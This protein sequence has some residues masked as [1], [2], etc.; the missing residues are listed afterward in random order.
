MRF[1]SLAVPAIAVTTTSSVFGAMRS[2]WRYVSDAV[3]ICPLTT[4]QIGGGTLEAHQK[5][6]VKDMTKKWKAGQYP[7]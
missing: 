1:K 4:R 2:C 5:N 3:A 6:M 7:F